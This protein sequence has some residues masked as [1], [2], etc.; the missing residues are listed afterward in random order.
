MG[1]VD[2]PAQSKK[3]LRG[4]LGPQAFRGAYDFIA[5]S[6]PVEPSSPIRNVLQNML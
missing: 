3:G 4:I 1:Q 6:I 5:Y 2:D